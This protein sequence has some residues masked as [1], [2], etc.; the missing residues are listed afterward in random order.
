MQVVRPGATRSAMHAKS[1]ATR[2]DYEWERFP[3]TEAVAAMIDRAIAGPPHWR[4][5]GVGN[6]LLHSAARNLPRVVERLVA[7]GVS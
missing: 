2:D 1:G 5:V 4:T 3:S 7:R 6:R